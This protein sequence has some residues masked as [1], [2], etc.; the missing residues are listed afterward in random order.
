MVIRDGRRV[1]GSRR[2]WGCALAL[3]AILIAP[4]ARALAQTFDA[5][6]VR[7]PLSEATWVS[8]A[9]TLRFGDHWG[10]ESLCL[11]MGF[12]F[13]RGVELRNGTIEFD[14]AAPGDIR[15]LGLAF[16]VI[17][18]DAY[19]MVFFRPGG[20]GTSEAIQYQP[21]LM[22]SGTW[23]LFHGPANGTADIPRDRWVPIKIEMAGSEARV[24]VDGETEP[25][26][27]ISDLALGVES[28]SLGFW[29]GSFGN[30]GYLSNLRYRVDEGTHSTRDSARHLTEWEISPAFDASDAPVGS[31]PEVGPD[32]WEAVHAEPWRLRGDSPPGIV[33]L[34]RYRRRPDISPSGTAA[35]ILAGGVPGSR[36]VFA[37]TTIESAGP[38]RR[39]LHFGYTDNVEIFLNGKPLFLGMN[40]LGLRALRGV[41]ERRGE[42]VYL[43]LR[44]GSNEL[45]FAV[46]E[47]LRGMGVLGRD[48]PSLTLSRGG[49]PG[50]RLLCFS[51][52]DAPRCAGARPASDPPDAAGR[53]SL[54]PRSRCV[55]SRCRPRARSET[56]PTPR[57]HRAWARC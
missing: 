9:D 4:G 45:V 54:D 30:G 29:T 37:R 42:S 18:A 25:Q 33:W 57:S 48:G 23:Q 38:E 10:R 49:R 7:V 2:R 1:S 34:N 32:A 39:R 53:S 50:S 31:I 51:A 17:S 55:R 13:A 21:G 36:V 24:Y 27:V 16:R 52:C 40:P 12:A 15:F 14:I 19:E 20:T 44:S 5:P 8:L 28:G 11:H 47:V 43:P 56:R 3:A 6:A 46:T 41:M 26:L 22:G 35:S